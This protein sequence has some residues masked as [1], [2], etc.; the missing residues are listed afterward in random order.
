M[1]GV[2]DIDLE[3]HQK[4]VGHGYTELL[5]DRH[6]PFF[7]VGTILKGHEFHY[8]GPVSTLKNNLGSAAMK[9]G[10]GMGNGRDGLTVKNTLALYTHLHA[11]GVKDWA[12]MMVSR[13][14]DYRQT[15]DSETKQ[16]PAEDDQQ[17]KEVSVVSGVYN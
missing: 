3:M 7:D 8:T 5:I 14:S 11:L 2:F 10:I 1:A 12:R 16:T 15:I 17:L 13:A 9:R 6:N 4:P